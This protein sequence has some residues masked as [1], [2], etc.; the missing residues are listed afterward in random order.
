MLVGL[1]SKRDDVGHVGHPCL[2]EGF[3]GVSAF[4]CHDLAPVGSE[5]MENTFDG[6]VGLFFIEF[7]NVLFFYAVDDALHTDVGNRLLQ[8]KFLLK[9]LRFFLE[10]EYFQGG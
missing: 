9:C 8:V 6:V 4:P 3:S 2:I 7:F 5:M 1:S 10:G